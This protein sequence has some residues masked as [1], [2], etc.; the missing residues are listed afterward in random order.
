M[1]KVNLVNI[2]LHAHLPYVKHMEYP[3]FLEEDWLF[4][5][6]NES[7]LPLLRMLEKLSCEDV[8]YRLTMC[9]SPTLMTML[10]DE[11]LQLRFLSYMERHLELGEKEI[12][13]TRESEPEALRMARYY[14]EKT[15]KNLELYKYYNQN[16]LEGFK[17]LA[18]EGKLELITTAATHAYLPLY[19]DYES[20]VRAQILEGVKTFEKAF[21]FKP[22]G[23]WL[24]ECG[25]YPGLETLL[26]EYGIEWCQLPSHSV[27][28]AKNKVST[29][30]YEPMTIVDSNVRGFAR[31]WALTNLVW[32]NSFGYPCDTD[33]REFYRDIGYDL[34]MDY[35]EPYIHEP[36]VRVFT[37]Y[38]YYAISGKSDEKHYYNL[39]KAVAK[40]DLHSDNM[41]YHIQRKGYMIQPMLKHSPVYNLCF[42]AELFGH[43]WFEGILFL[44]AF[45]RKCEKSDFVY[46]ST[47]SLT[48]AKFLE[49]EKIYPNTCSW[50]Y[51]GY[52]DTLLDGS[53]AWIYPH[54]TK[55]ISRMEEL[56]VRFKDQTSLR[57]RFLNQA[58][59]EVLLAMASDWP[60]I[61]HDHTSTE[62]A[63]TRLRNHLGSFN[64][65]YTNMCKNAV[66]TEWLINAEKRNAI[67]PDFD[68]N[69]F[70]K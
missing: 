63:E 48:S 34:P 60:Y 20:A 19:K 54:I 21:G 41:L 66:N 16:I 50:L 39:D 61:L 31:D 51:G 24:P 28:T 58:G 68:Y 55:A 53:N 46:L 2:I 10:Q 40:V 65:A 22:R 47:P 59:R 64:L 56:A 4:E 37:G 17:K 30:G 13:R 33:Y 62:Y 15:I 6:L 45:I 14:Y 43:R 35:I 44:E 32:S 5:S 57:A 29:F 26:E 12:V 8:S 11:D 27:I 1:Q 18:S 3:R 67:F 42:D 52:A 9:F 7:Y 36:Q 70:G 69:I 25:Y 49:P 23:F 38:K